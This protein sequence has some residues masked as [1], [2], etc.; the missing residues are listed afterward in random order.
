MSTNYDTASL[1]EIDSVDVVALAPLAMDRRPLA[2]RLFGGLPEVQLT[3]SQAENIANLWRALPRG[4]TMRCHVPPYRLRFRLAGTVVVE[5]SP[6]WEGN[7]ALGSEGGRPIHFAFD[8]EAP[9]SRK[10]LDTLKA[11]LPLEAA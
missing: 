10:L 11:A 2:A 3:G 4:E 1:G 9:V 7:N 8:A 5:A 6:C